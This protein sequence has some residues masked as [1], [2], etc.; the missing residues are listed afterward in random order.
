MIHLFLKA[1]RKGLVKT[2]LAVTLGDEGALEAYRVMLDYVL[3]TLEP[4]DQ[5]ELCFTPSNSEQELL[6]FRRREE[7]RLADQ[8]EG[9]LGQ[10]LTN[11]FARS[12]DNGSNFAIAIGADSPDMNSEDL[13]NAM[14]QLKES[15]LVLGPAEDGGYWLVGMRK[16]EPA[17]FQGIEWS[18]PNVLQQT[19]D[20]ARNYRLKV[21]LLRTLSD[22]DTAADWGRFQCSIR[23]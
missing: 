12:F 23:T 5:V 20:I 11:A 17:I 13:R 14:S 15:D 3:D 1:P 22:I 19:L 21:T 6:L 2:R 16:F 8:G 4:F 18:S 7:W 10:R 9:D